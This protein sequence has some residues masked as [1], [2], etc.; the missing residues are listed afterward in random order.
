MTSRTLASC[1]GIFFGL[2]LTLSSHAQTWTGSDVGAVAAPGSYSV[3][4]TSFTVRASGADIWNSADEFYFVYRT[5]VGDGEITAQVAS[6][7][8]TN[9]WTKSGVML[10]ESLAANSRFA[11]MCVTPGRGAAFHYRLTTGAGAAPSNSGDLV[12]KAPYWVKVKRQG[13][14][15]SGYLSADGANWTLRKSITL[16]NLAATVYVG[17]ALT[18]HLDGTVATSVLQNPLVTTASGGTTPDTAPPTTPQNLSAAAT[19][20]AISLSWNP[21]TDSGGSGLAGYRIFRN[22]STAPLATAGG[23]SYSDTTVVQGANYSY[24]VRAFDA[25]GNLSAASNGLTVIPDWTP[26]NAPTGLQTT[27]VAKNRVD[28]KWSPP[29]DNVKTTGYRIYRNGVEIGTSSSASFSDKSVG[30]KVTVT[31]T[32]KAFDAAGN[33][34]SA[35]NSLVVNVP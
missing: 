32:V 7:T 16:S 30:T 23:T 33:L 21:S 6:I 11:L 31:Y 25:A 27:R 9:E 10:R 34:S 28:L 1:F 8:D 12:T 15:V 3:N 5:L 17:L 18:S 14:T 35:S 22:G 4:G 20:A 13:T 26:P 24:T 29:S 2:S 19:S